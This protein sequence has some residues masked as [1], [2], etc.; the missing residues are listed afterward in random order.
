MADY[1]VAALEAMNRVLCVPPPNERERE[2]RRETQWSGL[3]P[4][5]V[6]PKHR[7]CRV[8]EHPAGRVSTPA[9]L[10]IRGRGSRVRCTAKLVS[11]CLPNRA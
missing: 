2:R 10:R 4:A 6:V 5:G 1:P 3:A 8:S 9:D 7:P 11:Q